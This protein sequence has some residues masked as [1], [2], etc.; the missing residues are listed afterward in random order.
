MR[1]HPG[2]YVTQSAWEDAEYNGAPLPDGAVPIS[3]L[4][5]G[6][7]VI[8]STRSP[9]NLTTGTYDGRHDK[10]S[11]DDFRAYIAKNVTRMEA[12]RQVA[13]AAQADSDHEAA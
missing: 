5:R 6:S 10:V 8:F 11:E 2:E 4:L 3:R 7:L 1:I 13:V 12:E 9:Y